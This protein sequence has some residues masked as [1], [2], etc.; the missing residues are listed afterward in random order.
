MRDFKTTNRLLYT[1]ATVA[2]IGVLF[3]AAPAFAIDDDEPARDEGFI[4]N[5]MR[6]LGATDGSNGINYRE[7]S[8][9]VV[10][11]QLTLPPPETQRP[12]AANWP[13][14]PDVLERRAAREA[15]KKR[16]KVLENEPAE[17]IRIQPEPLGQARARTAT[18][19]PQPGLSEERR[20]IN[21]GSGILSPSQ[22]GVTKNLFG[23]FGS[24]REDNV[25]FTS[26]PTRESLTQPPPGYQTPSSNQAYGISEVDRAQPLNEQVTNPSGILAPGKF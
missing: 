2:T 24:K 21:E 9:L 13:K 6:G 14:D 26:E 11:R 22:L 23:L 16:N 17:Q 8:P 18:A 7:R 3:T 5:L 1:I 10:P 4:G 12:T 25:P 20:L 19:A 15:I